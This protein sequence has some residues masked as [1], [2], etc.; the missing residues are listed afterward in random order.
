MLNIWTQNEEVCRTEN[1]RYW[2]S[3]QYL[4]FKRY[5][6]GDQRSSKGL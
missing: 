2:G 4:L 3:S 1:I 5:N 6:Y